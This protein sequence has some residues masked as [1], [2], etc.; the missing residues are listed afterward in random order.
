MHVALTLVCI[1]RRNFE[2]VVLPVLVVLVV[3]IV[4]VVLVVLVY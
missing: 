3:L 2:T 4:L 1:A